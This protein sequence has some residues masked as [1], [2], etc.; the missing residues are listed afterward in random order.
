M[1]ALL[2]FLMAS[3]RV[4]IGSYDQGY[5]GEISNANIGTTRRNT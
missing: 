1:D 2:A 4:H 3:S 5:K